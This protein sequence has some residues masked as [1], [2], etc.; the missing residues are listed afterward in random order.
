MILISQSA[1][2]FALTVALLLLLVGRWWMIRFS[3]WL[4]VQS[5]AAQCY[6]SSARS[7]ASSARAFACFARVE[8]RLEQ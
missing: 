8:A 1:D 3:M 2:E 5:R 7:Y 4:R 6:A